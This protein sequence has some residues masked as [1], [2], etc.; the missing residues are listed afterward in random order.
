VI[1]NLILAT[2]V[3]GFISTSAA[4]IALGMTLY[5]LHKRARLQAEER[6]AASMAAR[7][8]MYRHGIE[9]ARV[10]GDVQERLLRATEPEPLR[11][12]LEPLRWI[13]GLFRRTRSSGMQQLPPR[14]PDAQPPEKRAGVGET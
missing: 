6:R 2:I 5:F 1:D 10:M 8:A 9:G 4:L 12:I 13:V 7:D 11:W 14:H 3:F